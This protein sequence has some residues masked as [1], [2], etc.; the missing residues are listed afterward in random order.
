MR[1]LLIIFIIKE[2][3]ARNVV[4]VEAFSCQKI[5]T[6]IKIL[7]KDQL[8]EAYCNLRNETK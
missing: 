3:I 8:E 4:N 1:Y 6:K 5:V 7:K 2:L